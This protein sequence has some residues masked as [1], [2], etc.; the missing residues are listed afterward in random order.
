[1]KKRCTFIVGKKLKLKLKTNTKK[2]YLLKIPTETKNF[3]IFIAEK[4]NSTI[5]S[6]D[7]S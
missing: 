2:K 6:I 7:I 1:M 4:N 5:N 3:A